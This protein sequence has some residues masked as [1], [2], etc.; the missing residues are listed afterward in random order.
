M[1]SFALMYQREDT[2]LLEYQA[3]PSL[4]LTAI[5]YLNWPAL[6]R[7]GLFST[8][9]SKSL[10]FHS[11]PCPTAF[12]FIARLLLIRLVSFHAYGEYFSK[13]DAKNGQMP[14]SFRAFSFNARFHFASSF[15]ALIFSFGI[16]QQH[17]FSYKL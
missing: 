17:L 11:V 2:G 5:F 7:F 10:F 8:F 3:M 9:R 6:E 12:I 4:R 1:A 13:D 16:L 15:T 14:I